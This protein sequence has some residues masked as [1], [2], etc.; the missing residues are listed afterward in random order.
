M[1]DRTL[2]PVWA[3]AF[4]KLPQ[5]TASSLYGWSGHLGPEVPRK[6]DSLA[7]SPPVSL[8]SHES[9]TVASSV[10]FGGEN[11]LRISSEK[12]KDVLNMASTQ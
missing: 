8:V 5:M 12:F 4:D 7:K 10:M 11:Q 9:D 6:I 2:S 3:D 1:E